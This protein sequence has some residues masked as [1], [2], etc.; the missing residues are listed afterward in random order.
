MLMSETMLGKELQDS[1]RESK[2]SRVKLG[3]T[4]METGRRKKHYFVFL[5]H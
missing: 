5:Y 4:T 1:L 3:N 2:C